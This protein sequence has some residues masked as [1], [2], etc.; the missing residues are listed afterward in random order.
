MFEIK[1]WNHFWNV[2]KWLFRPR[3]TWFHNKVQMDPVKCRYYEQTD[4]NNVAQG[5]SYLEARDLTLSSDREHVIILRRDLNNHCLLALEEKAW[6]SVNGVLMTSLPLYLVST[7]FCFILSRPVLSNRC[8]S[9]PVIRKFTGT[10]PWRWRNK[11]LETSKI[12]FFNFISAAKRNSSQ[13]C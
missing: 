6:I 10:L 4:V 12:I 11:W 1:C 5:F 3:V 13:V 9:F 2:L 8:I 7:V